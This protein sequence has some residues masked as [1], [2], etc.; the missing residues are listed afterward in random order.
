MI[1]SVLE[2]IKYMGHLW[3]LTLLRVYLGWS[4]L[5]VGIERIHQGYFSEAYLN[6]SIRI[7][8]QDHRAP[9]WYAF[10]LESFVQQNWK[11]FA[12]GLTSF[13]IAIGLSLLFGFLV[14]PMTL[15]AVLLSLHSV[16]ALGS[17]SANYYQLL[18]F[19]HSVLFLLGAGR[20]LGL[21][22]YFFRTRRGLWW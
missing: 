17:S 12:Y 1:L 4:Y 13:E 9:D 5:N 20:C 21:D 2:S 3:P 8:L 15:V 14:R 10:F 18:I 16:W 11:L 6:E 19:V 22:Y 7:G